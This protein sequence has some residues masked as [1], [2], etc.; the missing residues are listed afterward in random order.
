M[1]DSILGQGKHGKDVGS[2]GTF[3]RVKVDFAKVLAHGLLASI[4]D[5]DINLTVPKEEMSTSV[6]I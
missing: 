3:D 5:E 1:R 6:C 4:V 2:E